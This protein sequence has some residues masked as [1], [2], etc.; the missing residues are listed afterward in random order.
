[1]S[2]TQRFRS[3][4]LIDQ[5]LEDPY[6]FEFFQAVRL[7]ELW[8]NED[9]PDARG[10]LPQALHFKNSLS[11]SFPP[12][13][14]ESLDLLMGEVEADEVVDESNPKR[15]IK[16]ARIDITPTF[17]SLL[18]L[19]GALPLVYTELIAESKLARGARSF[20]DLFNDRLVGLFYLAWRKGRPHLSH[21]TRQK[22]QFLSMALSLAGF[23]QDSLQERLHPKMGGVSDESLA[24]FAGAIQQRVLSAVQL[25]NILTGYFGVPIKLEQFVG[26]WFDL[27]KEAQWELGK[28][29]GCLGASALA[30]ERIWQRSLCV[31]VIVGPLDHEHFRRFLPGA[32][33]ALGLKSMITAL[34]GVS[35]DYEIQLS[36]AASAVQGVTLDSNRSE[37]MG[38]LGWD[39][40]LRTQ[41]ETQNRTDV[42]YSVQVDAPVG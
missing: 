8:L 13:E 39:S 21:E 37:W 23:G 11:L 28:N 5:L 24:Y 40:Y 34:S 3:T 20:L 19:H 9:N 16:P 26:R 12:G 30:G 38:L 2:L 1:M 32:S 7:L 42:H 29:M 17:M 6:R 10:A 31:R 22:N 25:Q 14:I 36:L 35:L 18:G 41:P 33:G 4:G 15:P 27:P